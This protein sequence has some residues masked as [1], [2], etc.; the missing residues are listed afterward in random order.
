MDNFIVLILH[1]LPFAVTTEV[2]LFCQ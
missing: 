2:E 1:C